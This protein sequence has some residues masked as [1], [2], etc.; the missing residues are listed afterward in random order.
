MSKKRTKVYYC[1][2]V[3]LKKI[4]NTLICYKIILY[5]LSTVYKYVSPEGG[6]GAK[7]YSCFLEK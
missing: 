7:T 6:G 1:S 4:I 3:N 2:Q 5:F